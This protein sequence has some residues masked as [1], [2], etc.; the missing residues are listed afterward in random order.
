[1]SSEGG[2][3][4]DRA[5]TVTQLLAKEGNHRAAETAW[6]MIS[7]ALT[8]LPGTPERYLLGAFVFESRAASL[9]ALECPGEASTELEAA[10]QSY[11]AAIQTAPALEGKADP[12]PSI[13]L[14]ASSGRAKC[15]AALMRHEDADRCFQDAEKARRTLEPSDELTAFG[16]GLAIARAEN[17]FAGRLP[18]DVEPD[19][20]T[21]ENEIAG[22]SE[23]AVF[24]GLLTLTLGALSADR[25]R[26]DE[27]EAQ[28]AKV[29]CLIPTL[30]SGDM[31]AMLQAALLGARAH[32]HAATGMHAEAALALEEA[33]EIM[34]TLPPRQ[35]NVDRQQG[36]LL[37]E[38][39]DNLAQLGRHEAAE[40]C[41]AQAQDSLDRFDDA[42]GVRM[43]VLVRLQRAA[44]GLGVGRL[45]HSQR[46]IEQALLL[47]EHLAGPIR[48]IE[49]LRTLATFAYAGCLQAL[50]NHA[51]ADQHYEQAMRAFA[52]IAS[53]E[54][55]PLVPAMIRM[56]RAINLHLMDR[57][58]EAEEHFRQARDLLE[59]PMG[60]PTGIELPFAQLKINQAL[61]FRSAGRIDDAD[62][63][64][65]EARRL[66]E[67]LQSD[68]DRSGVLSGL[69]FHQACTLWVRG[70][71]HEAD[72][73]F[74]QAIMALG[75]RDGSD[76]LHFSR[77]WI[78]RNRML[79]LVEADRSAEAAR[80]LGA[81][82]DDVTALVSFV[83]ADLPDLMLSAG[84]LAHCI[85]DAGALDDAATLEV[86]R[87][88][89]RFAFEW[90]DLFPCGHAAPRSRASDG[91]HDGLADRSLTEAEGPAMPA[92]TSVACLVEQVLGWQV[93]NGHLD[94]VCPL[95]AEQ[96]ERRA[97]ALRLAFAAHAA[98]AGPRT[99]ALAPG[100]E[101]AAR[102]ERAKHQLQEASARAFSVGAAASPDQA[103]QRLLDDRRQLLARIQATISGLRGSAP[104]DPQAAAFTAEGLGRLLL[105]HLGAQSSLV[106]LF[107]TIAAAGA[108]SAGARAL[109][110][111][112][113]ATRFERIDL[114]PSV[115]AALDGE[116]TSQQWGGRPRRQ[117]VL[118]GWDSIR[119]WLGS[120]AGEV[121]VAVHHDLV[122][123]PWQTAEDEAEPALR[124]RL[125][126]VPGIG[127]AAQLIAEGPA[128]PVAPPG[129]GRVLAV[130]AHTPA[131]PVPDGEG[132]RR[133]VGRPG[134]EAGPIPGVAVDRAFT[135]ALYP[136]AEDLHGREALLETTCRLVQV[137]CHADALSALTGI[138]STR[139]GAAEWAQ[140][141]HHA[142][143]RLDACVLVACT[144]GRVAYDSWGQSAG[145]AVSLQ[146][147]SKLTVG[148]LL[149]VDDRLCGLFV[150]L[151]H[152][153]WRSTGDLRDAM[154]ETR[155]ALRSGRW[156]P[157]GALATELLQ[158]WKEAITVASA[159]DSRIGADWLGRADR[160]FEMRTRLYDGGERPAQALRR[161][162][163]IADGFVLFG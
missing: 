128:R 21:L 68:A 127:N 3:S 95:L 159:L 91:R 113:G 102:L 38:R 140:A 26:H 131:G 55:S 145:W 57:R 126:V 101:E 23:L 43:R 47:L 100:L 52:E 83:G 88:L 31:T 84:A 99:E 24:Q 75:D 40:Q 12:E 6:A 92:S 158:Q 119:P 77:A 45:V 150:V 155:R 1:M 30:E 161:L 98:R 2:L 67:S 41:Y 96:A 160:Y 76:A 74:D 123:L 141:L 22:R 120:P 122:E 153:Y 110:V 108:K 111:V 60:V 36:L 66:V 104:I 125:R 34:G 17:A 28:F 20:R 73:Y 89:T 147:V 118:D 152:R 42:Q 53:G 71:H 162:Q 82:L 130:L 135:R 121:V 80:H 137:S 48:G 142:D 62:R 87:R 85:H 54:L 115:S 146:P 144:T 109:I 78:I 90:L 61:S 151:L 15:F 64:L 70:R 4:I 117:A 94:A 33:S 106:V 163:D 51:K 154:I 143:R 97:V 39:A 63:S 138:G 49:A 129:P 32:S 93:D 5:I 59:R 79:N 156:A 81:L 124:R 105:D 103:D 29:E 134:D 27:A 9:Q 25:G 50:G 7:Q 37:A 116:V 10:I 148:A 56:D 112:A 72:H 149:P 65:A 11:A 136:Q 14:R 132:G 107:S 58:A 35:P 69:D 157:D 13:I 16:V 133:G 19:L 46:L 18:V 86:Q 8:D 44:N 114:P 139:T